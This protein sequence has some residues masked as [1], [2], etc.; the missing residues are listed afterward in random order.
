MERAMMNARRRQNVD[1]SG[2]KSPPTHSILSFD[3]SEIVDRANKIGISLGTTMQQ[4]LDSVRTIKG[5]E[6][7]RTLIMLQ[8]NIAESIDGDIGP[9]NLVVSKVSNLCEDLISDGEEDVVLDDK[10]DHLIPNIVP[11]KT[12]QRKVYDVSNVRR[13][14]R[15]R[16]KK[17]YS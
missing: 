10:L 12:R 17:I 4:A 16:T 5:V 14:T 15:R 2:I 11:Q 13:S 9:S 7:E 8:K 3:D 1:G 6:E